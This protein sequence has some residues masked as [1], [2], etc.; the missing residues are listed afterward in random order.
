MRVC[1]GGRQSPDGSKTG[2]GEPVGA[3]MG[4]N[5]EVSV[6]CGTGRRAQQSRGSDLTAAVM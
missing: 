1:R 3:A 2:G 4:L 5:T 6:R